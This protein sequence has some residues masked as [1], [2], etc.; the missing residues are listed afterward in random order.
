M[1]ILL[2]NP[3]HDNYKD[4]YPWGVLLVGSYLSSV[5]Y[6]K[7]KLLDASVYSRHEFLEKVKHFISKVKLVGIACFSTDT[8]FVKEIADYIKKINEDCKIIVGG[9]HAVLQP[10]Q[11]C[12]YKNIDFVAYT[13]GERTLSL[14][15]EEINSGNHEYDRV[16]GLIYK[17]KDSVKRTLNPEP[18]DFF[19]INYD[20]LDESVRQTFPGYIQVITGKGCSFRCT[21]CYNSI[22]GQKWRGKPMAELISEIKKIVTRYNTKEIYFRDDNFFQRKERVKEF[23]SC[24]KENGFTFKWRATCRA[25]YF[26]KDY[27]NVEFLKELESV[28][29]KMLKFGFESGSQRM[30]DYLKKGNK[31]DTMWQLVSALSEVKTIQGNYSFMIGMPGETFEEYK[32]TLSFVRYLARQDPDALIIGPQYFRVYAGGEL[33]EDVKR[34][35]NYSEPGS[36]E[37][38]AVKYDPEADMFGLGKSISYPWIPERYELLA[39]YADFMVTLLRQNVKQNLNIKRIW[40]L[41]FIFL[42]KI[43]FKYEWYDFLYDIRLVAFLYKLVKNLQRTG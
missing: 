43:R 17:D 18:I 15:L 12:L 25:N 27:I 38:W 3:D 14:L 16:P 11:T 9:P 22:S 21:F 40:V 2:I 28:N 33:Y 20:L 13:E 35:Y 34:V 23:I 30:L 7:V 26:K 41:P 24:Y 5:K 39:K 36:F 8:S 4:N 6:Y 37:E 32:A 29:C 42:A 1:D 19:D 10:E 31:V